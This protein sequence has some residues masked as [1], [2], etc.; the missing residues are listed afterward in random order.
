MN[1]LNKLA[2][3]KLIA[4]ATACGLLASAMIDAQTWLAVA[5]VYIG[6]QAAVDAAAAFRK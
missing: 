1:Y 6:G 5:C 2:S 4:F 3:R